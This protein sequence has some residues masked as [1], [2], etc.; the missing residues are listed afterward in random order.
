MTGNQ[1][2]NFNKLDIFIDAKPDGENTFSGTPDYDF[3]SGSGWISSNVAGFGDG[4]TFEADYLCLTNT[5]FSLCGKDVHPLP[6][7]PSSRSIDTL[8]GVRRQRNGCFSGLGGSSQ[9]DLGEPGS[10]GHSE[11][12]TSAATCRFSEIGY[13]TSGGA[14]QTPPDADK[15]VAR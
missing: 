6:M 5:P 11:L 7:S 8:N 4:S 13:V 2:P 14:A 15:G 9:R 10:I 1:E 12:G 3:N